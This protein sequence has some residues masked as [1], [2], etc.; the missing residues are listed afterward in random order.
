VQ[1]QK[2]PATNRAEHYLMNA[3]SIKYCRNPLEDGQFQHEWLEDARRI[4][5]FNYG[6]LAI[7][8]RRLLISI[9]LVVPESPGSPAWKYL[10]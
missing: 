10:A 8:M 6:Y 7:A 9:A 4:T 1:Q 5:T 3:R 2:H